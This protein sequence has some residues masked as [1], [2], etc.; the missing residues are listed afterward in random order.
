MIPK[1]EKE[2]IIRLWT[3]L[4]KSLCSY[5][6]NFHS[7]NLKM[8]GPEDLF[9]NTEGIRQDIKSLLKNELQDI[10]NSLKIDR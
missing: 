9:D 4:Y 6:N 3:V 2:E 7:V 1:E 10:R 5:Y 8:N